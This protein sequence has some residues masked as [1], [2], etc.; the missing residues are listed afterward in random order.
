[1]LYEIVVENET[2]G[3]GGETNFDFKYIPDYH[4]TTKKGKKKHPVVTPNRGSIERTNLISFGVACVAVGVGG[5]LGMKSLQIGWGVAGSLFQV[6]K[7][8]N[9]SII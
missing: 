2:L 1:M 6:V 8:M 4:F 3:L 9:V 7:E 5:W